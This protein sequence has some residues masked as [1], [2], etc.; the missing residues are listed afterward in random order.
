[1]RAG[2][3]GSGSGDMTLQDALALFRR[4]GL[5]AQSLSRQEFDAGY[6]QLARRFHPDTN[7]GASDLM[8]NLNRARRTIL[9]S[10]KRA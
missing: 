4:L 10:Y 9:I 3:G 5:D 2:S 1:M 8:A 6:Y 7:P